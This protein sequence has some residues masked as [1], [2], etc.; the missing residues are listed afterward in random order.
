M[1]TWKKPVIQTAECSLEVTAYSPAEM[2]DR[3]ET[4]QRQGG[5]AR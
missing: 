3:P 2:G 5:A 1:K 4:A